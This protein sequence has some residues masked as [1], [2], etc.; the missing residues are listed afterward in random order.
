M[1]LRSVE[2]PEEPVSS[3]EFIGKL[4]EWWKDKTASREEWKHWAAT[5]NV[6]WIADHGEEG[7]R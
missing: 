1:D 3:A 7:A 5:I 4:R 2:R 6:R